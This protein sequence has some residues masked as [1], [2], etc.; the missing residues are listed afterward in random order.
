[1]MI[2]LGGFLAA[3]IASRGLLNKILSTICKFK[4]RHSHLG[5]VKVAE[6]INKCFQ[7][8]DDNILKTAKE[9]MT[10]VDS[11]TRDF[12]MKPGCCVV[13]VVIVENTL[14]TCNVGSVSI[15][16]YSFLY[17]SFV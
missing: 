16:I 9:K 11:K 7:S 17:N 10:D 12:Y 2:P 6:I 5:N 4:A 13:V 14:Y 3:D 15:N 8:T 1:M